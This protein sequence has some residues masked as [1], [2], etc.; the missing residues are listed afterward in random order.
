MS[1]RRPPAALAALALLATATLTAAPAHAAAPDDGPAATAEPARLSLDDFE[2]YAD[3]AALGATYVRNSNGGASTATLVDSPF[4]A[5]GT[6]GTATGSAMRFD[7]SF[8]S[9][10]SG[11]SRAVDGYWP[12]LQAL[13]LWITNGTPGQDVLLQLSDGASYE[14]HLNDVDGFDAT[15]TEPQHV[16]VPIEDFRPKS[17]TGT[18]RTSGIA[19]FA[20]YVNQV[21]GAPGQSGGTIVVDEIDLLL[22]ELPEA[23][24]VSFPQTDLSTDGATNLLTVLNEHATLPAGARIVQAMWAS[25]DQAVLHDA[26]RPVPKGDF[27]AT[28][29]V[30]VDLHEVRLFAPAPDGGVGTTFTVDVGTHLDVTVTDL[31]A[32]VDVVDYLDQ[33]TG[34]GMLSAM[35]HDQSYASA[36]DSLHQRVA[37][38]FGV[39][40]ALYSA[41]FLTGQTVPYRQQMI[42]EVARQ[43]DEGNLVQIMFHVSPPQ[44]TVAQEAE[45][46]WGGDQAHE[47]LP[48]PN[49]I[50]SYLYADQW[51]ELMTYGT[52]LN[53]SWKERMDEYARYLQ[54]LE[55]RGVTVMLRP[56]H[57]MNQHVFW[58]GGRPGTDG[59]AGL[60]R[61]FHDYLEQDKGLS[62]IVWV[63]NV[64]DLP[65]DYGFADGDAKFDRYE[66]LD[67]GLAEYDANDWSSFSPGAD[68]YDVLSVDF[69]DVEGYQPR[70]YEQAQQIA[71][72]DGKPMMIGETFVFPT[73]DEVAAQPDWSLAMPWGARTWNYNTPQAM[74]EFY[75]HSIGAAGMPRFASRGDGGDAGPEIVDARVVGVVNPHG[76]EVS[77]LAVRYSQELPASELD[78]AAFAVRADLDGPT[79]GTTSDGPRT[80]VR[81]VTSDVPDAAPGA[82]PS[83]GEWVVLELDTSDANAA[84]TFYEGTT[85]LYDLTDA[86]SVRQVGGV[87]LGD[88]TVAGG[89]AADASAVISPV[90]DEYTADRWDG[91]GDTFRYR[92]FTPEAVREDPATDELYPLVLT[93]HGTGETG[94]DN[95]AQLVGNQL[96]VAFAD[97]ARQ[98]DDPAFV[99]SPQRAPDQDWLTPSGRQ[100]LVGM[101]EDMID[102]Y[103]VDPDRVYLTGLSRGSR[104]S[105]PLLAENPDLFAGALLVA[106][107]ESADLTAQIEDLPVWVHHAIDDPTAPYGLTLTALDGL[108]RAGAVVTRGEWAGNLPRDEAS[109]EAQALWDEARAAGSEVLHTAYTPGT[110]GTPDRLAYPHS[111]WIPT[112]SNPV[113]LD[114]LFDQSRDAGAPAPEVEVDASARCLAGKAYVAVRATNAGDSAVDV[115]LTTPYGSRTFTGVA[116]GQNAYQSF[117]VRAS[118]VPDGA[119]TVTATGTSTGPHDEVVV[120]A[121]YG[122]VTCG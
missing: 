66:G 31:P 39:Y 99:L 42:D 96:S 67:G 30:G 65:D 3:D 111:S 21:A 57:E 38:E 90:V 17:G 9:G 109:A 86:Y 49:R 103:P 53:E 12:G 32:P 108:E 68:Y 63:W 20:L 91:P 61:M 78:P 52:P 88:V 119:A 84:G 110:T 59:S 60:Y 1:R 94:T 69:Y 105:W 48:S 45:G 34:T 87:T 120:E 5:D 73:Q 4:P 83:A 58:W 44:Y 115:T 14:A 85:Q 62:N 112:Y 28:G 16:T 100:A 101:V 2:G 81:A 79:P 11:R 19:S 76:Y 104:A 113:V 98:G 27:R 36:Q 55:D 25:D 71:Q 40:P 56:F 77:A 22:D 29:T 122:A 43:W 64:Q 89:G 117:A 106:G 93:L 13:E 95:T 82:G 15:S 121:D 97:P 80:V 8:T 47:T 102:R 118:S 51:D 23:P 33:I 54:Q 6:D 24:A 107:G 74:E 7:Y 70:H 41:D 50:Y 116:P 10:Y 37:N 46:G 75:A 26:T 35:H 114:W 72:R 18:L 92:L